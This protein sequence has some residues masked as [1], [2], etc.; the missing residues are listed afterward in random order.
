MH[1][2]LFI[3]SNRLPITIENI[4]NKLTYRQS[5]GG[6]ISAVNAYLNSNGKDTF[7]DKIWCGV[8]E[9]TEKNWGLGIEYFSQTDYKYAPVF[10]ENDIYQAYYNGFSNSL[11]WPLFHYFPSYA[12]YSLANFEAYMQANQQFAEVL[13]KQI[14]KD[15]VVWIHD[16][17]LL[18]LAGILRKKFPSTTI[19]FFLHI[20]FPSYELF[21]VIPKQWQREI[22]SGM[23]G[24]DLVGFH[25]V[26]YATHF[27]ACLETV[28][29]LEHDG[30]HVSWEN[31]Q[32]KVDAFPIS[33]DF[34]LFHDAYYN[35]EVEEIRNDY[36]ALKGNK[37]LIFSVDRL[38]Y[39]KGLLN[40]LKGF[41][42]FLVQNT[43][44]VGKVLF[45]LVIVP[46]RD[47]IDKYADR[48]KNIDEYIGQLNGTLGNITWQPVIYQYNHLTFSELIAL[49][50]ACDVAL[51]TPLRD[52]MNLVAK[53]FVASRQDK[54]GAL[55]LSEMAGA[56]RELTEALLINPNDNR[57]IAAMIKQGL[58]MEDKEQEERIT[59]MQERIQ[60]YDVK[61]WAEDFFNQLFSLKNLQHKFE[62]KFLDSFGKSALLER[63]AT[64]KRRLLLLDYDGTLVPFSKKPSLASPES[65]LIR[66]LKDLS[67]SPATDVYIVSGRDSETL[68][69]WLGHLPIGLIAEHGAKT[70]HKGA[71]WIADVE[72]AT[73]DWK[74]CVERIMNKYLPKCPHSFIEKKDFSLAWHYRNSDLIQGGVRAKELYQE[75]LDNTLKLSLDVLDGNKVIE[76]RNKGIN[77][78]SAISNVIIGANYDFIVCIGDDKTDE[79]MFKL[80][81]PYSEAYTIKVGNEYSHARYN[82]YTPYLVQSLLQNIAE[83]PDKQIHS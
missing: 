68:E 29:K 12:E 36:V 17:H 83:F 34:D 78:G 76:V 1:K 55:I 11:L 49:Y 10:L 32:V 80:L 65:S 62:I 21:R 16:Y 60:K 63:Y 72:G 30:Q 25:T 64:S 82:L 23:L 77:K 69:K 51:I 53:E 22:L 15:D 57:E 14:R 48:K 2:R 31:R 44:Y 3:V 74:V 54:K 73:N 61:A 39:T 26:D 75:L 19:G 38:D 41:K 42:K 27:L 20:P 8:S 52:G 40:R 56:S 59:A 18:P 66:T 37:K 70:R 35:T 13:M 6:L 50:T 46:S 67:K 58:E 28:L 43:E 45:I 33:I 71:E 79:D 81:L 5:S 4:D 7:T 47:T 24:A 9:C